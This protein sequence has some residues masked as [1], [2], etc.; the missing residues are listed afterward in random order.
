MSEIKVEIKVTVKR[1]VEV[2]LTLCNLLTDSYFISKRAILNKENEW[3]NELTVSKDGKNAD[4]IGMRV[5]LKE[6]VYPEDYFELKANKCHSSLTYL[7]N[8]YDLTK[9]GEYTVQYHYTNINPKTDRL[10]KI[11]AE[12]VTFSIIP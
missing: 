4:Y 5:K 9:P 10:D 3:L 11:H 8:Y 7:N 2:E 12:E 1:D 6:E